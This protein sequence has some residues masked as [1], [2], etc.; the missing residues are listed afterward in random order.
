MDECRHRNCAEPVDIDSVWCQR[1]TD[2]IHC[3]GTIDGDIVDWPQHPNRTAWP[4]SA[5]R[6]GFLPSDG[7]DLVDLLLADGSRLSK[8]AA[9]E[10]TDLRRVLR[11]QTIELIDR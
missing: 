9:D 4:D 1:H 3:G 5:R 2:I 6:L 8:R 10:I 11:A 7:T